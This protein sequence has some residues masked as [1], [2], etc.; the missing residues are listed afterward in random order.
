MET[1]IA[2]FKWET[3]DPPI[4][5]RKQV[6]TLNRLTL[7]DIPSII[8]G[9]ENENIEFKEHAVGVVNIAKCIAAFANTN[10]GRIIIGYNERFKKITGCSVTDNRAVDSAIMLLNNAPTI[11]C[12]ELPYQGHTLL[13][14]DI[15]KSQHKFTI[16]KGSVYYRQGSRIVKMDVEEF[17]E[18]YER[19]KTSNRSMRNMLIIVIVIML[20]TLLLVSILPEIPLSNEFENL[21][22]L[23]TVSSVTL[24]L[25]A[26]L[27]GV[28]TTFYSTIRDKDQNQIRSDIDSY[29]RQL[30]KVII[31]KPV[32]HDD[33]HDVHTRTTEEVNVLELMR[34]NLVSIKEYYIWSQKQAKSAFYLAITMCILGFIIIAL[35]VYFLFTAHLSWQDSILPTIGGVV[36]ELVAGTSLVVYRNSLEQ[37]NHYHQALHEDERFLSSVSL[38]THFSTVEARDEMLREIIRSELQMN[39]STLNT[40]GKA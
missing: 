14:V 16:L 19:G 26:S 28:I 35:T 40:D 21:D 34:T 8:D 13:V 2:R 30:N 5:P 18:S 38:L 12:Y 23:L 20:F 15:E 36:I 25:T 24:T 37:L 4:N 31:Q 6:S 29:N 17:I 33:D 22:S 11:D 7:S 3:F 39:C 9:G 32:V 27:L 1:C 10:G